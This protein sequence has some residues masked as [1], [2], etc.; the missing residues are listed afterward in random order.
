MHVLAIHVIFI[1]T[2]LSVVNIYVNSYFEPTVVILTRCF[3]AVAELLVNSD[4][5]DI[6]I[7]KYG[8]YSVA[9]P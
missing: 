2:I 1:V 5:K 9:G 7:P 3:S 6:Q 4:T 8:S